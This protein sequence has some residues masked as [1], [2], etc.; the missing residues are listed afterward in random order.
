[1]QQP[2]PSFVQRCA[3][4]AVASSLGASR[5]GSGHDGLSVS[6]LLYGTGLLEAQP[7][8]LWISSKNRLQCD[9]NMEA[10]ISFV[11]C[12]RRPNADRDTGSLKENDR[13]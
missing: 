5:K 7:T 1:M 10:E 13:I 2:S 6:S 4:P 12:L 11:F 8:E 3:L 9:L